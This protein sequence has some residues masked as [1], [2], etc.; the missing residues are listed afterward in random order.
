MVPEEFHDMAESLERALFTFES[1]SNHAV[2]RLYRRE[3]ASAEESIASLAEENTMLSGADS[4]SIFLVYLCALSYYPRY[5]IAYPSTAS[6]SH[7]KSLRKSS[8]VLWML[9]GVFASYRE[10]DGPLQ[11]F[12]RHHRASL[13]G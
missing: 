4:E 13:F 9:S 10:G 5:C 8:Y 7:Y 12:S 11:I 3:C 1:T 6:S 2:V